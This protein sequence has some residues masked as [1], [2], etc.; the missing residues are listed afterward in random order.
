MNEQNFKI[1]LSYDGSKYAGFQR[2]KELATVQGVLEAALS[3]IVETD[4]KIAVA[5][6]TDAGVHALG[7]VTSAKLNTRHSP[8]LLHKALNGSLPRDIRVLEVLLVPISFHAR[9]SA[10]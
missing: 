8:G 6:R 5:G 9:Y 2:Q 3:R 4:V 10:L 1:T 7:Q